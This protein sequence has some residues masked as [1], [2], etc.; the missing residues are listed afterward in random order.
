MGRRWRRCVASSPSR[1]TG[2]K[3]FDRYKES[4]LEVLTDRSR[5]HER[6]HSTLKTQ[7][8]RPAG[9]NSL[10]QQSKFDDFLEEFNHERPHEALGMKCPAEVY[11]PATRH[12][13]GL[14]E[15]TYPFHDH[16]IYVTNCGRICRHRKNQSQHCFR[17]TGGRNQRGRRRYLAGQLMDYDLGYIDL[18]EKTL[19][20]LDNPFGPKV[21]PM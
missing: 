19:Q 16:T 8:T 2:Y 12:Y 5:R 20:P 15:L 21:L 10:Q 11:T 1:K 6:M 14:P 17:G 9:L 18:E 7:T 3:I 4:G 13:G